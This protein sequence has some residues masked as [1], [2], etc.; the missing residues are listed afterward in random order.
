MEATGSLASRLLGREFTDHVQPYGS[1]TILVDSVQVHDAVAEHGTRANVW[2]P[3][4]P[5]P[6]LTLSGVVVRGTESSFFCGV[7]LGEPRDLSGERHT[8]RGVGP[9]ELRSMEQITAICG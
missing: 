1:R 4:G 8:A 3:Y 2:P 9:R 5:H 6:V 7:R